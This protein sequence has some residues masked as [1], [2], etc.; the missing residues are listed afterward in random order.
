M[1]GLKFLRINSVINLGPSFRY[2]IPYLYPYGDHYNSP[3]AVI[4]SVLGRLNTK[5]EIGDR[6]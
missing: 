6:H 1:F 2:E 3:K 4:D 5:F